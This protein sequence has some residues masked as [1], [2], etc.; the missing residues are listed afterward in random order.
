MRKYSYSSGKYY[1]HF[2]TKILHFSLVQSHTYP[3]GPTFSFIYQWLYSSLLGPCLSFSFV[4]FIIQLVGPLGRVISPSQGRYMH[5][6]QHKHRIDANTDIHTLSGIRT[7]D[8]S[9]RARED[10][11]Y[12]RPCGHSDRPRASFSTNKSKLFCANSLTKGARGSIV[13]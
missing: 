1:S 7:H 5:T 9:F 12:L 8:P 10:N 6:G 3:I 2:H 4:I 11:S 13:G